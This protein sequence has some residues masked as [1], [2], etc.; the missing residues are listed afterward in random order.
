M[1]SNIY[2]LLIAAVL[3]SLGFMMTGRASDPRD[4][5][6]FLL[7]MPDLS[8]PLSTITA[9]LTNAEIARRELQ[10]YGIAWRPRPAALRMIAT[11][12]T[13]EFPSPRPT[14]ASVLSATKL[15]FV[16]RH[17]PEQTLSRVPDLAAVR[18]QDIREWRVPGTPIVI[19]RISSGP[20][21]GQFLF[22]S[23]TVAVAGELYSE[24]K[25]EFHGSAHLTPVDELSYY[26]G[27]L[28]PR[29]FIDGLPPLL[30]TSIAGQAVWQW[31]GL[32]LLLGV[33]VTAMVRTAL[34]GI[35]RDGY[36]TRALRRFG[37]IVASA[38]ITMISVAT[39]ALA[40]FGLKIWGVPLQAL[41]T[42]LKLT[43]FL[44]VAWLAVAVVRRAADAIIEIRGV[45]PTSI[46]GQ[47]VRV[48]S[49]L[50]NITIVLCAGFFIA[51]FV[52]VPLG[53]LLA[54][55]GIGGLAMALAVRSTLENVIGGLT[56]FA[57]RPVRVGEFC[58]I[59]AESGTVEEIGLR[60]TK[61]RHLDDVVITIPNAEMAQI[62]IANTTRRRKFLFNPRL[63][64]RYETT[65]LQIK[66]IQS[67]I[68]TMLAQHPRV[69]DDEYRVRL[70]GFGDYAINLDIFAYIDVTRP[71]DFVVVQEELNFLIM[72]I[73]K[74]AGTAF[75]FPSQTNYVAHDALSAGAGVV[76]SRT[77]APA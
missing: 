52:D 74:A 59:G 16:L 23:G 39:L 3:I 9:L 31:I 54:G 24:L 33:S 69:L 51:D 42:V 62:R 50:L 11:L 8:S 27:P 19:V 4:E 30:L 71:A 44:S 13:S 48:L 73:V 67:D 61:I 58:Q 28:I 12:E 56:L 70:A 47:L 77:Q 72:E 32:L 43:L 68:L 60:T 25:S 53:P 63:G 17:L 76:A 37:Q 46:D 49:T 38:A 41:M 75:A 40:F 64:L 34:W 15:A 2:R 5:E 22:S 21:S 14:V 36:E 1:S 55:L 20:R 6:P 66:R 65:D 45:R 57:D 10:A 26:P 18:Q 7:S 35:R 29:R